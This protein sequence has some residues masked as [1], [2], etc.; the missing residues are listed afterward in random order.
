MLERKKLNRIKDFILKMPKK[1]EVGKFLRIFIFLFFAVSITMNWGTVKGIFEYQ[2]IYGSVINSFY[3][4]ETK[5]PEVQEKI[6]MKV[7]EVELNEPKN[8]EKLNNI[9]IPKIGITAPI[10]FVESNDEKVFEKALKNGVVH[11]PESVLPGENGK[12]VI[13]GHSA[14]S[15][16]PKINYDWVFSRLNELDTGDEV[17][18]YFENKEYRYLV[19]DKTFLNQGE[20]ILLT[21]SESVVMLLSCWPP[22]VNQRRIAV[23][24]ELSNY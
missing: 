9:K 24:A 12:T 8:I 3:A 17:F 1:E 11:Y 18:I 2:N 10:I 4:Q 22:G 13:L 20:E 14:P 16:W 23:Q 5:E 19:F 15:G 7:P 6:V 21:N